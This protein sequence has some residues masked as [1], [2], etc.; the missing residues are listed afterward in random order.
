MNTARKTFWEK[1][2]QNPY[3]QVSDVYEKRGEIYRLIGE[4]DK[5]LFDFRRLQVVAEAQRNEIKKADAIKHQGLVSLVKGEFGIAEKHYNHALKKYITHEN[6]TGQVECYNGLGKLMQY[7]ENN[8]KAYEYYS[9]GLALC[10]SNG[11]KKNE[12][13][14]LENIAD[15]YHANRKEQEAIDIVKGLA[16]YYESLSDKKNIAHAYEMI[17][18]LYSDAG[19][20]DLAMK[21]LNI[22]EDMAVKIGDASTLLNIFCYE[23]IV[24]FKSRRFERA[25]EMFNKC[26]E[27]AQKQGTKYMQAV[28]L[29]NIGDVYNEL[30][31]F[32]EAREHLDKMKSLNIDIPGLNQEAQRIL[33]ELDIKERR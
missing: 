2:Y 26:Y 23:G 17:G 1:F 11:D 13:K 33:N 12:C 20:Y 29:L 25:N 24:D 9:S 15:C 19:N 22:S 6:L 28:S 5:A 3:G 30:S 21:Y 27:L 4:Y 16:V 7:L 10:K 31:M 14:C 8:E 32:R 18:S